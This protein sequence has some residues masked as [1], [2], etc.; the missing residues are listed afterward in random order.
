MVTPAQEWQRSRSIAAANV[1]DVFSL[2]VVDEFLYRFS[3][4]PDVVTGLAQVPLR[5][6]KR[7]F[8]LCAVVHFNP[9][10]SAMLIS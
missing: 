6:L 5:L 7:Q 1:K 2:E 8:D 9:V 3:S 10:C 4:N